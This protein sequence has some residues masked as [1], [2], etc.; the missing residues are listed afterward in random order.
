MI[1]ERASTWVTAVLPL[2]PPVLWGKHS[3]RAPESSENG[4]MSGPGL[5]RASTGPLRAFTG[6]AGSTGSTGRARALRGS[7]GLYGPCALRALRAVRALPVSTGPATLLQLLIVTTSTTTTTW[8]TR[9]VSRTYSACKRFRTP[10]KL[11]KS[12]CICLE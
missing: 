4:T 9:V 7:Y 6:R 5:L 12:T 3:R 10:C 11:F 8:K 1:P 2:D